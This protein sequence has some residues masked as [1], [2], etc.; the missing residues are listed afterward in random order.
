M[1]DVVQ[2][3]DEGISRAQLIRRIVEHFPMFDL[4]QPF[5]R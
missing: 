5:R 1:N 2:A 3:A 4:R